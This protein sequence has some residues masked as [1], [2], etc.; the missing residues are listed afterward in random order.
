[1]IAG[2]AARD[3]RTGGLARVHRSGLWLAK[4]G[5]VGLGLGMVRREM[6]EVGERL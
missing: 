2:L 1:V 3:A 5:P 6:L 4:V